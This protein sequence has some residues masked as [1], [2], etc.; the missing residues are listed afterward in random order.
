MK[1]EKRLLKLS[2]AGGLFFAVLGLAWGIGLN[3]EMLFFDGLYSLVSL[4][5]SVITI[6]IC[7]YMDKKDR[8]NFPFGKES[9]R[10]IVV[11]IKSI[12]LVLM[13]LI[14]L[15]NSLKTILIGG[16]SID[17][18]FAIIY[19]IISII[20][21]GSIYIYM[22]ISSKKLNSDI[23][24]AESNQWLMDGLISLGVFIGFI[25][26]LILKRTSLSFLCNYVDPLMVIISSSFFLKF[27]LASMCNSFNEV[28]Q[29]KA[30][31]DIYDQITKIVKDIENEYGI[32]ESVTRVSK[33]G[34]ML[35][36]EID[37]ILS[38]HSKINTIEEMDQIRDKVDY[39]TNSINLKKWL[40]ISFTKNRKWAV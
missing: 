16:N 26:V 28:I 36:I 30:S 9:L 33:V 24:K 5:L 40:N 21:C 6:F 37:F 12:V 17:I 39:S 18:S 38:K 19:T 4:L 27:P 34:N 23:L 10:P 29:G 32:S 35:R 1:I 13:C 2:A 22:Y 11:I 8:I 25:L 15:F 20:G 14:S 7:S 31:D 3:S